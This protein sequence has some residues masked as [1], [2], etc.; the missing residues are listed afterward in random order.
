MA[1]PAKPKH[2]TWA[3]GPKCAHPLARI[4]RIWVVPSTPVGAGYQ[5]ASIGPWYRAQVGVELGLSDRVYTDE[6]TVVQIT[7]MIDPRNMT[8][9]TS[10]PIA[11]GLVLVVLGD[12][13]FGI[14][15]NKEMPLGPA[16]RPNLGI[17]VEGQMITINGIIYTNL[18]VYQ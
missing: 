14:A 1:P 17:P 7:F 3:T 6:N 15:G 18:A 12:C 2:P 16:L 5:R 4:T 10:L 8:T 13:L 11:P 9:N